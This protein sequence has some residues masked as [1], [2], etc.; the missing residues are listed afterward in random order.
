MYFM[1]ENSRIVGKKEEIERRNIKILQTALL[2]RK[3]IDPLILSFNVLK[4]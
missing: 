3:K 1:L 2:Y 4:Y